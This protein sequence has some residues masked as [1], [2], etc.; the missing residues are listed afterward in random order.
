M[1]GPFDYAFEYVNQSY[2]FMCVD[3]KCVL[4][5]NTRLIIWCKR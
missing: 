2:G 3:K 1:N 5:H 4:L